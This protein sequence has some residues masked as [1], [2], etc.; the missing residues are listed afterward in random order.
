MRI[1][2]R[3]LG[4]IITIYLTV[5]IILILTAGITANHLLK[6]KAKDLAEYGIGMKNPALY[7]QI[8]REAA[9]E[10]VEPWKYIYEHLLLEKYGL[11]KNPFIMGIQLL[12]NKGEPLKTQIDKRKERE[13]NLLRATLVTLTVMLSSMALI[14]VFGVLFGMKLANH[15]RLLEIVEGITRFFNG[16]PSWWVGV[17]LIVIFAVKL[18]ILPTGGLFTPKHLHGVAYIID[19]M[20]HLV[21]PIATLF[22]VFIWEFMS[23]VAR[24]TQ[25]EMY[26]PYIQ[27]ERA[28]GVPE[29]IIYRKHV[30]RNIGIVVSS[31]TAQK[32][33]EMFTD[34]LIIDYLFGL[35]GLGLVLKNSF[36]REIIPNVGINV[37][38]N[39]Y[40]FFA[41]TLIIATISFAASLLL[42]LLKGII[43]PRVS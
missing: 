35:M 20:K 36:V 6:E 19:L 40:L 29:R 28:K 8:K 30:L 9:K 32:F 15:S 4:K 18:N 24:E 26:Q 16:L 12:L 21:L 1:A 42:E 10:G 23:I 38:F 7:E 37:T 2:K 11:A 27:T 39:F 25:K 34:Y 22:L 17:L 41:T 31:F 33:M 13:L 5:M 43:D 3:A 14:V